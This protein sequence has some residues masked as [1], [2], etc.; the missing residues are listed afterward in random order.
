[1]QAYDDGHRWGHITTNLV[2]CVTSVLKRARNLPITILV[3]ATYFQLAKLFAWKGSE[4]HAQKNAEHIFS[5][6]VTIR[7]Q[8]N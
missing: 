4:A 8:V 6:A 3:R 1:M 2:E 7:L 5:K